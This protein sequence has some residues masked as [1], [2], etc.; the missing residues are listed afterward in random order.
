MTEVGQSLIRAAKEAA[1]IARGETLHTENAE[2]KR[3]LG[4]GC[5]AANGGDH[6]VIREGRYSFCGECGESLTGIRY[7]HK[8]AK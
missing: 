6:T 4:G 3:R 2:L 8:P 5:D 1:A 7:C